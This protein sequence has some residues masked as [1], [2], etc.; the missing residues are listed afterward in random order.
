MES[1]VENRGPFIVFRI[2]DDGA[3]I[4]R[5]EIAELSFP[6]RKGSNG[7]REWLGRPGTGLTVAQNIVS[8][9]GGKILCESLE[10]SGSS[11]S[12]WLPSAF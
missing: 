5:G 11:F 8:A 1:R 2:R 9:H 4:P 7:A 12:V 10:G 3:G 6:F